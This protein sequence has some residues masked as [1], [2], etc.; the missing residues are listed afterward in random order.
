LS[1]FR[2]QKQIL[3]L[4][5]ALDLQRR[6]MSVILLGEKSKKAAGP[7]KQYQSERMSEDQI[8]AAFAKAPFSNIGIVTGTI[9]GVMVLDVDGPQGI[10]SLKEIGHIPA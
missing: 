2:W 10:E 6:G 9:S 8:R 3:L 4:K 5:E 7:W 1:Q